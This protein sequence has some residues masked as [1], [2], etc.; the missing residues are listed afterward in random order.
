MPEPG[1]PEFDVLVRLASGLRLAD[2]FAGR[3]RLFGRRGYS[4]LRGWRR[5]GGRWRRCNRS[6]RIL[7]H[8]LEQNV[9]SGGGR[10]RRCNRNRRILLHFPRSK[11]RTRAQ[12]YCPRQGTDPLRRKTRRVSKIMR[13]V[14]TRPSALLLGPCWDHG[15]AEPFDLQGQVPDAV[16]R[17]SAPGTKRTSRWHQLM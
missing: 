17:T 1:S 9:V 11:V 6:R 14:S 15:T 3:F 5:G 8:L 2:C 13:S 16:T 12:D 4:V 7:L 10:W